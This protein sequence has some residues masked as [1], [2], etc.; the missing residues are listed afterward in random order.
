MTFTDELVGAVEAFGRVPI[1]L[2]ACD[3]DGTLAPIVDDPTVAHPLRPA[4]A[5]LRSLAALPDTHVSVISGRSLRDLAVLSR[6]PHEVH[7]VGSHG[8]EFEP[9]SAGFLNPEQRSLLPT[10][11]SGWPRSPQPIRGARWS[12]SRPASRSTTAG[13][14]P[15]WRPTQ[16]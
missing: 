14:I 12:P 13:R 8:S 10:W 1:V 16:P 7:L 4:I 2:I 9:D 6:L 3:Y 15:R 11:P 5:A